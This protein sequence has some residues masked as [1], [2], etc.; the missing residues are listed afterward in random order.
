MILL[1]F[2][3][4]REV[5]RHMIFGV[6]EA[7]RLKVC[8]RLTL[9]KL[10]RMIAD[11][12]WW[13]I[14]LKVL[15]G[16]MLLMRRPVP[17]FRTIW[18]VSWR[19]MRL[20]P[21]PFSSVFMA[22][23]SRR[24]VMTW[25]SAVPISTLVI[26]S[27]RFFLFVRVMVF[28][29]VVFATTLIV[30]MLMMPWRFLASASAWILASWMMV[31][32]VV[33]LFSILLFWICCS[34]LRTVLRSPS[35][36]FLRGFLSFITVWTRFLMLIWKW[37]FGIKGQ[38][39]DWTLI[40]RFVGTVKTLLEVFHSVLV[41]LNVHSQDFAEHFYHLFPLNMKTIHELI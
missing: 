29:G 14:M 3:G 4:W 21:L 28:W 15:N 16:F 7:F 19:L 24:P 9:S 2:K 36:S 39:W 40:E 26:V 1:L 6:L 30:K 11:F 38:S 31:L 32:V 12:F 17:Q 25:G 35:I 33:T 10:I 23:R 20:M 37:N 34:K 13:P 8:V 22:F 5:F 27:F 41:L 18:R